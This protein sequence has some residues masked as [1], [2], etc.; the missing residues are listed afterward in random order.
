M[1]RKRN[2]YFAAFVACHGANVRLVI[3]EANGISAASVT[4]HCQ[5]CYLLP[6]VNLTVVLARCRSFISLAG[7]HH[8]QCGGSEVVHFV[9]ATK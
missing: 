5:N 4:A 8:H 9:Q 2:N 7:A 1:L 3:K 6:L